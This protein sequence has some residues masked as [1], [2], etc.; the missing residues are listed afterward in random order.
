MN[1][2]TTTLP[3]SQGSSFQS[4]AKKAVFKQLESLQEG[5]L[6]INDGGVRHVFGLGEGSDIYGELNVVDRACYRHYDWW[7]YRR[8]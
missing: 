7:K 4:L 5:Q 6:V 1:S 2:Q 3:T 8:G